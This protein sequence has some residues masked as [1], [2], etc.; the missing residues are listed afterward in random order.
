MLRLQCPAMAWMARRRRGRTC[1]VSRPVV[2]QTEYPGKEE[3]TVSVV[4]SRGQSC[5]VPFV[6]CGMH[7]YKLQWGD[8]KIS[9]CGDRRVMGG[10]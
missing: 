9:R 5:A 3:R 1:R 8:A 4:G 10:S 7:I 2:A 6:F